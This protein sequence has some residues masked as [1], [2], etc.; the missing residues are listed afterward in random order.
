MEIFPIPKIKV[1]T[2]LVDIDGDEMTRVIWKYVREKVNLTYIISYNIMIIII[3]INL[4]VFT[5]T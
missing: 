2:P 4:F 5:F 3:I 1:D